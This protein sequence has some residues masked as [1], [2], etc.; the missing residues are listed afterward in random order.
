MKKNIFFPLFLVLT[1]S[2]ADKSATGPSKSAGDTSPASVEKKT[3][4]GNEAIPVKKTEIA[5]ENRNITLAKKSGCWACHR[6]DKK[7]VGPAWNDVA[8]RYKGKDALSQ[9]VE[10]V[11]KGGK[12]NWEEVTGGIAMPP[13]SPRV[14]DQNIETLVKYI[15]TLTP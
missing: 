2:C 14:S 10:K 3:D 6:L 9:L 4:A 7:L 5:A 8:E 13:N 11:K 15:L 12:G 1:I